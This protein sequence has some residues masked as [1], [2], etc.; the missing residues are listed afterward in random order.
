MF[1]RTAFDLNDYIEYTEGASYVLTAETD[2]SV[3]PSATVPEYIELIGI[4][5]GSSPDISGAI[6]DLFSGNT[7][8]T[9]GKE[10]IY[11]VWYDVVIDGNLYRCKTEEILPPVSGSVT[12]R[13]VNTDD[14]GKT[15]RIAVYNS[16]FSDCKAVITGEDSD[17]NVMI[18]TE[19]YIVAESI[20]TAEIS[21]ES[22]NTLIFKV[23]Q[24]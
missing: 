6:Y 11:N 2:F 12:I 21:G 24:E 16:T 9:L 15:A 23:T 5:D 10:E 13:S 20:S 4:A 14:S 19:L 17:G 3:S 7:E 1:S 8:I 18:T 22:L